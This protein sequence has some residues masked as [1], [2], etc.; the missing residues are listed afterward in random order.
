[1]PSSV[2]IDFPPNLEARAAALGRKLADRVSHVVGALPTQPQGPVLLAKAVG[3]DKVLTSR[4][5]RAAASRDP[6]AV[7]QL[8]PGPDPLRGFA[9][10]AGKKGVPTNLVKDLIESADDFDAMIRVEAG[11]RGGFDAILASWLPEARAEFELRRKQAVFRAM[12]QL[13]GIA[14]D[15]YVASA[16]IAPNP[17]GAHLDVVWT[18]G[19]MGLQRLRPNAPFK[20]VSRRVSAPHAPNDAKPPRHPLTLDGHESEGIEGLL[21]RGYCTSPLPP[22]SVTRAGDSMHYA[23]ADDLFG[24]RS[25]RDLVFCEVNLAELPRAIPATPKRKRFVYT[26]ISTPASLLVFDLLLHKDIRGPSDAGLLIYDTGAQGT[27]NVNDPARDVDRLD[28]SESIASLGSGL[29]KTRISEAPWYTAHL[30][31]ICEKRGWNPGDFHPYR[32]RIDYPL[33]GT[34]IALTYDGLTA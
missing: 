25:L 23:L 9:T 19:Y 11:D 7:L 24:P 2:Q 16:M 29:A 26:D 32:T 14:A 6:I 31:T 5:L 22:L 1:M 12:S 27:A 15:A 30:Q 33:Y 4:L 34:Q 28:L 20:L 17:D 18:F 3:V 8:M 10:A 13:K 21:I